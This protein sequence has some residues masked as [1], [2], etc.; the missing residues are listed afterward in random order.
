MELTESSH[1]PSSSSPSRGQSS[2]LHGWV[3]AGMANPAMALASPGFVEA[4]LWAGERARALAG[5]RGP[6]SPEK[7]VLFVFFPFF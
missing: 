7:E 4:N 3:R 6:G 5:A 1:P 2:E